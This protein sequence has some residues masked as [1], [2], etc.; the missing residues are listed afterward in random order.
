MIKNSWAVSQEHMHRSQIAIRIIQPRWIYREQWQNLW[1]KNHRFS[2][3]T[4]TIIVITSPN[5]IGYI[6]S[7]ENRATDCRAT[8]CEAEPAK[9]GD[10][11]SRNPGSQK[12]R[13]PIDMSWA[14]EPVNQWASASYPKNQQAR[15]SEPMN[16]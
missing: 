4:A 1:V 6:I 8:K 11:K 10:Q 15:V 5:G 13:S 14:S 2:R 7:D 16:Y 9:S 3:K 12:S